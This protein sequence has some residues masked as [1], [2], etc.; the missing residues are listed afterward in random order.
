MVLRIT[1]RG[2]ATAAG[3]AAAAIT[4]LRPILSRYRIGSPRAHLE[5]PRDRPVRVRSITVEPC[6]DQHNAPTPARERAGT[7]FANTMNIPI[8]IGAAT[9]VAERTAVERL[10]LAAL[11]LFVVT[12]WMLR[13]PY[14]GII[15]DAQIYTL[16]AL[17]R[18]HP[19][20]LSYDI[21]LRFGSQD[22]YTVFSPIYAVAIRWLD[23]DPAAALLTLVSEFALYGSA[24]LCA[25]RFM[26][27]RTALLGVGLLAVLPADYGSLTIFHCT[28]DFLTPRLGAEALVLAGLAACAGSR[29]K[30]GGACV[31]LAMVLHPIIGSAGIALALCAF[32]A[33]P[34]PRMTVALF[35]AGLV[36]SLLL[37][38]AGDHGLFSRFDPVWFQRVRTDSFL[39]P[40]L[41]SLRDWSRASV[42]VAVLLSGLLTSRDERVRR[43]YLATV[44]MAAIGL[45]LTLLYCD[46]LRVIIATDAQLWRWLWLTTVI[47]IGFA[48]LIARVCWNNGGSARAVPILLAAAWLLRS[49]PAGLILSFAAVACAA[50]TEKVKSPRAARLLVIGSALVFAGALAVYLLIA[51][52]YHEINGFTGSIGSIVVQVVRERTRDGAACVALLVL[53]WNLSGRI[54]GIRG[55]AV[56][57]GAVVLLCVGVGAVTAQ[58]WTTFYY[59]KRQAARFGDWRRAIPPHAEVMWS[60]EPVGTWYLLDRPSYFAGAQAPGPTFSRRKALEIGRRA[61][62]IGQALED[63]SEV[64]AARTVD[65]E[66][67]S[68]VYADRA[69]P[70]QLA[71]MC[72][73]PALAFFVTWSDLGPTPFKPVTPNP[74]KP[75]S[76]LHLYRCTDVRDM[77]RQNEL[78]A[79][80]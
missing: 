8:R 76:R 59:T 58:S 40:S 14:A 11:A 25:R 38:A 74:E 24:Y 48:P 21:Y 64:T 63:G 1:V 71:L 7:D 30:L 43:L 26:P 73:D 19:Q 60:E 9:R 18:L 20:Q 52:S 69:R 27:P 31:V 72:R 32:V 78:P 17:A 47:A 79:N 67:P 65:D 44:I 75:R 70:R 35:A 13:H 62:L 16:L 15:H 45:L 41:W 4:S 36:V 49:Y 51:S 80:D 46:L 61:D 28:E 37:L 34:R 23:L 3:R 29:Y 2:Y 53:L 6:L 66:R 55:A 12:A 5:E 57:A 42:P 22:S 10:K 50:S 54:G 33:I 56:L 68:P 77:A 39:L